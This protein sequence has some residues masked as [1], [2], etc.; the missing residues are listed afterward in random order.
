[1]VLQFVSRP[2]WMKNIMEVVGDLDKTGFCDWM[3][4]KP[5]LSRLRKNGRQ[6]GVT[7]SIDTHMRSLL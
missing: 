5:N 3:G 2:G 4:Q 7:S 1:M 6:R